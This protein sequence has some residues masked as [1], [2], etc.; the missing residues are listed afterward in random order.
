MY[1]LLSRR[2]TILAQALTH[3]FQSLVALIVSTMTKFE[4]KFSIDV[5]V[6]SNFVSRNEKKT[7]ESQ[8]HCSYCFS[9]K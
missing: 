5:A 4:R 2:P 9:F 3:N 7:N 6:N 8:V 1:D